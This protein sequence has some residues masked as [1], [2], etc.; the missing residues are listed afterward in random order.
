MGYYAMIRHGGNIHA[1]NLNGI[2]IL[3][4]VVVKLC[5][6]RAI[7]SVLETLS[8]WGVDH[9]TQFSKGQNIWH[10]LM[11]YP[12]KNFVIPIDPLCISP[13]KDG[14]TPLMIA[15]K[16]HTI[17][18][19]VQLYASHPISNKDTT[20][21]ARYA[22]KEGMGSISTWIDYISADDIRHRDS[23]ENGST[24]LLLQLIKPSTTAAEFKSLLRR[25]KKK[26]ST[27]TKAYLNEKLL[28]KNGLPSKSIIEVAVE[29]DNIAVLTVLQEHR[30]ENG[31]KD[32]VFELAKQYK[33]NNILLHLASTSKK[34]RQSHSKLLLEAIRWYATAE[35]SVTQKAIINL[36]DMKDMLKSII[37][38]PAKEGNATDK[39]SF[40][41]HCSTFQLLC[42]RR[43]QSVIYAIFRN[44]KK[45]D[46]MEMAMETEP[47]FDNN[48]LH[49]LCVGGDVTKLMGKLQ[50][51]CSSRYL[52]DTII[53]TKFIQESG[54]LTQVNKHGDTPLQLLDA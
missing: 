4:R 5:Q 24:T 19:P 43:I 38:V 34:L 44:I 49:F 13:D 41:D 21:V 23:D 11:E 29:A 10:F 28:D 6:E 27:D 16:T 2:S 14:I 42:A 40:I 31:K 1:T 51:K 39:T 50:Q 46:L 18:L 8:A 53:K 15:L 25:V 47:T 32:D 26:L 20:S 30:V 54:L 33:S 52:V 7:S 9:S 3:E 35:A 17:S 48:F 36:I 37:K 22:V 45:F 12:K